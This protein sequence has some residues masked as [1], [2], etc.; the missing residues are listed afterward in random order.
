MIRYL[1]AAQPRILQT[2]AFGVLTHRH[3]LFVRLIG[4][5]LG[6]GEIVEFRFL[7][8][9]RRLPLT[10]LIPEWI[11]L[12]AGLG[13]AWY[14]RRSQGRSFGPLKQLGRSTPRK[15]WMAIGLLMVVSIA[16]RLAYWGTTP[17]PEPAVH[18]EFANLL[19][20]ETYAHGRLTNPSPAFWTHFETYHELM[21]PTYISKYPPGQALFLT[22]GEI[23]TGNAFAGVVFSCALMVAGLYWALMGMMP[24]RW[25][26]L[27]ALLACAQVSWTSYWDNSYWGGAVAAFGGCLVVGAAV[28]LR[29][30][31]TALNGGLMALGLWLLA[32]TRPYEGLLLALPVAAFVLVGLVR[33]RQK[34]G[35]AIALLALLLVLGAGMGWLGYDNWR[36]TGHLSRLPEAE[37][38]RQY[39][40]IPAFFWGKLGTPARTTATTQKNQYL[41]IGVADYLES[42][43]VKGFAHN[44][45]ARVVDIW[46]FYVG[47]AL[48]L[49]PFGLLLYA[50]ARKLRWLWATLVVMIVGWEGEIWTHPHYYAPGLVILFALEVFGLRALYVWKRSRRTGAMLVGGSLLG[51]VIACVLRLFL[52]PVSGL[53][54]KPGQPGEDDVFRASRQSVLAV[55][56]HIPGD[57]LVMIHY[58]PEHNPSYEWVYNGYDIPSQRIIWAHDLDPE[59]PD[60]PLICHYRDRHVWLLE[61]SDTDPWTPQQ[62]RDALKPINTATLCGDGTSSDSR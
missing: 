37:Q 54:N 5:L 25:A 6:Y 3:G 30:R 40:P 44:S 60:K 7:H 27:G 14:F 20:A 51:M 1:A 34:D 33:T 35:L 31:L 43:T 49:L 22:L 56:D 57:D 4:N 36:V 52:V 24:R 50:R 47:P 45:V 58:P 39:Q 10:G 21:V 18:D 61:P 11:A 12:A 62:A 17:L 13:I 59:D 15:T 28:R 26:L 48:T 2:G 23:V 41:P 53:V 42:R 46:L 19:A 8:F 55:L 38:D 16:G 32:A 29:S 9:S